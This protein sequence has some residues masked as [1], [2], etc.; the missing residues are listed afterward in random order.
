M[1]SKGNE[2][3]IISTRA[4]RSPRDLT[5]LLANFNISNF[6][7][8]ARFFSS[9]PCNLLSF[10]SIYNQISQTNVFHA[11]AYP[12]EVGGVGEVLGGL[13]GGLVHG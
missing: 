2:W 12:G 11:N 9:A 13:E 6:L 8:L 5:K 10:S 4:S 3:G 7:Y 1:F